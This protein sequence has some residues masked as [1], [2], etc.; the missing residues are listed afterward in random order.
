MTLK[1]QLTLFVQGR[2]ASGTKK[3]PTKRKAT[4]Q[5]TEDGDEMTGGDNAGPS[6]AVKKAP[7]RKRAPAKKAKSEIAAAPAPTNVSG[8][9]SGFF[10]QPVLATNAPGMTDDRDLDAEGETD[11]EFLASLQRRHEKGLK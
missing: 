5:D 8:V 1:T 11:D 2:A 3:A 7:V 4:T 9:P 10:S 6:T